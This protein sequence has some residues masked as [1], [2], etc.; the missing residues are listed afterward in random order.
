MARLFEL[1]QQVWEASW[2]G[3]AHGAGP[4]P[5]W[6]Q[7]ALLIRELATKNNPE[8]TA[9]E[10]AATALLRTMRVFSAFAPE[11]EHRL[12]LLPLLSVLIGVLRES[13]SDAEV[14]NRLVI[15]GETLIE[16]GSDDE[17]G[18]S[19][20]GENLIVY[21]PELL[22]FM[23]L[24]VSIYDGTTDFRRVGADVTIRRSNMVVA[25]AGLSSPD[26]GLTWCA[27][28]LMGRMDDTALLVHEER[29]FLSAYHADQH[30][31]FRLSWGLGTK[32]P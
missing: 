9:T 13:S 25:R 16:L 2:G 7:T 20:E 14:P 31:G 11:D 22:R 30:Y 29:Y 21:R 17:T 27:L 15:G 6:E 32:G 23:V 5:Y 1:E 18:E 24:F 12:R 28:L 10:Y 3:R 8:A 26:P 19:T 4:R